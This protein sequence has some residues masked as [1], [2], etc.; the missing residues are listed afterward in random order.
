MIE[1]F[2]TDVNDLDQ[3]G[4]LLEC[5]HSSFQGYKANFD[6]EDCDNILR[7]A[8][9]NEH[10]DATQVI[11]LLKHHGFNAQVLPE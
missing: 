7:I 2:A 3:A 1:V 4:L 9:H 11:A 6:L 10:V 5:I 8:S